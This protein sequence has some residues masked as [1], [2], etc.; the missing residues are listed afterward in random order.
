[1]LADDGA[2]GG[3]ELKPGKKESARMRTPMKHAATA[4]VQRTA[5]LRIA[6]LREQLPMP[7]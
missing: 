7:V 5:M 2:G 6:D 1:L 3:T 4:A